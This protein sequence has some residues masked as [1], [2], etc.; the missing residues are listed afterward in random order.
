MSMEYNTNKFTLFLTERKQSNYKRS[1]AIIT[2][3]NL[4]NLKRGERPFYNP[5]TLNQSSK[6][7]HNKEEPIPNCQMFL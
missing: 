2:W 6:L 4:N 5:H 7:P 3:S 1:L